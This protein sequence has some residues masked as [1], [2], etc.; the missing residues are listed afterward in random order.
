VVASV[1]VAAVA[2]PV[3]ATVIATASVV[4]PVVPAAVV[5]VVAVAVDP[6]VEE[7]DVTGR[8]AVAASA[9]RGRRCGSLLRKPKAALVGQ[10]NLVVSTV[11]R[12]NTHVVR[13][14]HSGCG[15][16][17]FVTVGVCF[18]RGKALE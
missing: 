18:E 8:L 1:I 9:G 17:H 14:G 2:V 16:P 15:T 10:R 4:S 7:L 13:S 12:P 5:P 3:V 11:S 6:S